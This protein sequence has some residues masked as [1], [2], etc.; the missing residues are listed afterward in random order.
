MTRQTIAPGIRRDAHG[1]EAKVKLRGE[2]R[3]ERF[4]A[5]ASLAEMQKWQARTR[6]ELRKVDPLDAAPRPSARGTLTAA[7]PRFLR[8]IEGRASFKADRSHLRA[9]LSVVGRHPKK[10]LGDLSPLLIA[11]E[12]INLAIAQ[13]R[14]APSTRAPRR[15]RV[16]TYTRDRATPAGVPA[17]STIKAYDRT[18]PA[19]SGAVVAVKTIRHRCRVLDELYRTLYG[20]GVSPVAGAKVPALVKTAPIAVDVEIVRRVAQALA[21]GDAQ[22]YARFCVLATTGQR[23]CQVMRAIPGDVNLTSA[24]W[25]VRSAKLEPAHTIT[26]NAEMAAAWRIFT[27]ADAWGD[28]DTTKH[29]RQ[30]HAAGWPDGIRPYCAR[31]SVMADALAVGVDLGDVQGLAGHTSP[32]TTRQ[33]YGPLAVPRQRTVSGKLDGRLPGIV[34]PQAIVAPTASQWVARRPKLPPTTTTRAIRNGAK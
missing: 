20:D 15:I 14:T 24:I 19:T 30:V 2:E 25:L 22:T 13:W 34:R 10:P 1:Y 32:L 9:W 4:P 23:P 31:H 6:K 21:H 18:T 3:Y 16:T 26:L 28:Y 33:F 7:V 8:Q 17:V 29:A 5:D 27:A 11:T 12:D